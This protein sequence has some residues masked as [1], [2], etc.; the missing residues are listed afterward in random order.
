MMLSPTTKLHLHYL[1][2]LSF[3][4][5]NQAFTAFLRKC[6]NPEAFFKEIKQLEASLD[7]G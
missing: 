2:R 5:R 4:L 3:C 7:G 1:S 6:T